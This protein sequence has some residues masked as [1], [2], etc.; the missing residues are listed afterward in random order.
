MKFYLKITAFLALILISK[1]TR[2][3]E[4]V[5]SATDERKLDSTTLTNYNQQGN[6]LE[7]AEHQQLQAVYK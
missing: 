6:L 4:D 5:A 1:L 3:T 7:K 2:E